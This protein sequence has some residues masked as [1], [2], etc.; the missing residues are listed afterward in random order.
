VSQF[1]GKPVVSTDTFI[2][3]VRTLTDYLE[4]AK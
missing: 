4:G 3:N 1:R 2:A